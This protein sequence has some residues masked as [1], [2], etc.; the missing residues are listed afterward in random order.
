MSQNRLPFWTHFVIWSLL[1]IFSQVMPNFCQIRKQIDSYT[2]VLTSESLTFTE[3][4]ALVSIN[5]LIKM[6]IL[7]L[8]EYSLIYFLS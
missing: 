1:R 6:K 3:L 5:G 4:G 8:E 7:K 2:N